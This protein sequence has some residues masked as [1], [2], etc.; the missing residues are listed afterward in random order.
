MSYIQRKN[1]E[2]S[3][4]E[5]LIKLWDEIGSIVVLSIILNRSTSSVQTHA[6]RL[7][8]PRRKDSQ[9]RHRRRWSRTEDRLL[10]AA[11]AKHT[12]G[13]KIKIYDVA[14]DLNRSVDAIATKLQEEYTS[15]EDLFAAIHIPEEIL[16][17]KNVGSK[18]R[19][20]KAY[21]GPGMVQDNRQKSRM[22]DCLTC[23]SPF[24]SEGAHNRICDKC[25]KNHE[26]DESI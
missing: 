22:R 19:D 9:Q 14:T 1:W 21:A 15:E 25:K 8:L 24:W 17:K 18:Q 16:A 20:Q 5:T 4:S 23:Q 7:S 10:S 2:K 3:E 13:G 26:N 11:I 6:S 12:D